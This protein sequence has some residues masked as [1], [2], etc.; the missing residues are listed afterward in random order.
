MCMVNL[1]QSSNII[2]IHTV[3]GTDLYTFYQK[4]LIKIHH[5]ITPKEPGQLSTIT[6]NVIS[7]IWIHLQNY[8]LYE[9]ACAFLK[10]GVGSV[11]MVNAEWLEESGHVLLEMVVNQYVK[12]RGFSSQVG[13]FLFD[14]VQSPRGMPFPRFKN[15][16]A[17]RCFHA[18]L[19]LALTIKFPEVTRSLHAEGIQQ[20]PPMHVG[21]NERE[22]QQNPQGHQY[23]IRRKW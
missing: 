3:K 7:C 4:E 9:A 20:V 13:C 8:Y 5:P 14:S 23:Y 11:Y 1:P 12:I 10:V 17:S 2:S 19:L 21:G 15:F 22:L 16:H 18:P 6:N